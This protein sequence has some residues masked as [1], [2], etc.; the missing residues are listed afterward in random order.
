MI[1]PASWTVTYFKILTA[2]VS[3]STSTAITSAMKP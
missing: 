1:V 3:G 2:A